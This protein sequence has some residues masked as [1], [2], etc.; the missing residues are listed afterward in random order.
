MHAR[1]A[2]AVLVVA[3]IALVALGGASARET[4]Y[5]GVLTVGLA[6][7]AAGGLDP[8]FL[9][10][11]GGTSSAVFNVICQGL[12]TTDKKL[13]VVPQLAIGMPTISADKLTYTVQLRQ[14]IMFNDDTPFNAQAVV[15]TYQ[16]DIALATQSGTANPLLTFT[17]TATGPFTVVFH[18]QS[19]Y[20]PFLQTLL[21]YIES[22]TQLQKLG[23]TGSAT[24][25]VGSDPICVGPFMYDSQIP[26]VSITVIKSP[27]YYEKYSVYLDK[28]VFLDETSTA[29]AA[30]DLEAGDIQAVNN[31]NS[32]DLPGIQADKNLSLV[33]APVDGD[34]SVYINLRP[35]SGNPLQQ[36]PNLLEAF[37]MAIDR[38]AL[39]KVLAPVATP[40]CTFIPPLS[41]YYDPG[42]KCTPYNPTEARKLV[43]ESGI[44][45][46]TI[47]LVA[48]NLTRQLLIS[49]FIQSEEQAVGINV[50]LDVELTA[51]ASAD[52][53][54]GNFEAIATFGSTFGSDPG[55]GMMQYLLP[56]SNQSGFST[57]QLS[58]I[59]S[60]YVK[61]TSVQ[62]H[63]KLLDVAQQI[64]LNARPV[65]VLYHVN[66][67]LAYN[68]CLT[69]MQVV[70]GGFYRLAYAQYAC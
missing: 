36:S 5:G 11:G 33:Q 24:G 64:I 66:M 1:P 47:H 52:S 35:N 48:V 15:T 56:S 10:N 28:I 51:Q 8:S 3:L 34:T 37:E 9:G 42:L 22:P 49:Q 53:N 58:L 7:G 63:R 17:A 69:G 62:S 20:S 13:N 18:L 38:N 21:T 59:L 4:K 46:P 50:I 40:G 2:G 30:A 61:S 29:V 68:S 43:A 19:R 16:H 12:Y 45:N 27:Y 57:P 65:I 41:P 55:L 32:G 60:N 26:G 70:N 14:G 23:S 25:N 67:F 6:N 31:L 44:P 54:D 39:A